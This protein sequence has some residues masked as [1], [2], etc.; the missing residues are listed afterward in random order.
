MKL[1]EIFNTKQEVNWKHNDQGWIG[2]FIFEN[3]KFKIFLDEYDALDKYSLIDFGF[4]V[5]DKWVVTNDQKSAGKILGVI[6]NA[7]IEKIKELTPDCILFGV[8]YKNGSVENRKSLY[9][10]IARLYA[11]GSSYH[12]HSD[13]IKT[14][15]GEYLILS[16]AN[17]SEEELT[18]INELASSVGL[19]S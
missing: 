8:N 12:V 18:K 5:D 17:F 7:F 11:K 19:K 10:R 3:K 16:K 6:L 13:W 9:E 15:N 1:D 14:K 4:T 2:E